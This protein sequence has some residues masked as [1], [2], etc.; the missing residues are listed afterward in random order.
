[1]KFRIYSH[2]DIT[3]FSMTKMRHRKSVAKKYDKLYNFIKM[4][5]LDDLILSPLSE[6]LLETENGLSV[7]GSDLIP[8]TYLAM[9]SKSTSFKF[10]TSKATRFY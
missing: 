7:W 10:H 6:R 8:Q 4:L 1:M 5:T 2:Y 9:I 3:E